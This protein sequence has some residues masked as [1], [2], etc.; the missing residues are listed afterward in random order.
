MGN[1]L[2]LPG[3]V[4][5]FEPVLTSIS[6]SHLHA[7]ERSRKEGEGGQTTTTRK[8]PDAYKHLLR[9]IPCLLVRNCK[10]QTRLNIL[11][12]KAIELGVP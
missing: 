7:S 4:M 5:L 2:M 9:T 1:R 11:S 10:G 12:S 8:M 6:A 3:I